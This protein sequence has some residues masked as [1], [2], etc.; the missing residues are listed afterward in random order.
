MIA[1]FCAVCY[2]TN[3]FEE[4]TSVRSFGMAR[5]W[6]SIGGYI[7]MILGLSF[8]QVP[9]IFSDIFNYIQRQGICSKSQGNYE[10]A[11]VNTERVIIPTPSY[12]ATRT[13]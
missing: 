5:L 10:T 7:G 2:S 8:L 11:T 1:I 9:H 4:T 12:P 13:L 3:L 6:A